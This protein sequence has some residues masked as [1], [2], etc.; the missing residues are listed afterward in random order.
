MLHFDMKPPF[1]SEIFL[2]KCRQLISEPDYQIIS[3]IPETKDAIL[4]EIGNDTIKRWLTFDTQLRDEL[5]KIRA[6]RRHVD[7]SKYLRR[8]SSASGAIPHIA[9][10]A[11]RSPSILEGEHLLDRE[12]WNFLN[13]LEFGHYFDLGFLVVYAY[14]LKILGRW[15]EVRSSDKDALLERTLQNA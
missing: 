11:H 15:E 7:P 2:D 5:V 8:D 6:G 14:K 10:A 13:E 12:R 1:S 3:A 9:L 4:D